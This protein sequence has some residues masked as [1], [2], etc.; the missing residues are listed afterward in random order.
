M[1]ILLIRQNVRPDTFPQGGGLKR[2]REW[3]R[4][5][6]RCAPRNDKWGVR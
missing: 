2:V 6:R 5:P 1:V 3:M 4:L